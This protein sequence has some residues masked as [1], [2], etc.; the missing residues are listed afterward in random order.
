MLSQTVEY[1]LR[2]VVFLADQAPQTTTTEQIAEA[3]K[4]P[5]AYLSKVLQ[6][7]SKA[8]LVRSQ[9]GLRGGF[10]LARGADE[11]TILQVVS[12]V[13]PIKR[14]RECPVGLAGHGIHLCPLH[15]RLDNA[16]AMVEEAFGE[17]S[18]AEILKEPTD[19]IPLCNFPPKQPMAQLGD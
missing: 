11:I 5:G 17:T 3:T 2:A 15:K 13:D 8:E 7:L 6:S 19:S 9:R 4:V 10:T 12:A 16:M 14:I 18:L 1:A